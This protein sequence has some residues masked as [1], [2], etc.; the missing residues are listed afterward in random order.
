MW[1]VVEKE[2][3]RK[4]HPQDTFSRSLDPLRVAALNKYV[5]GVWAPLLAVRALFTIDENC[6]LFL[7]RA[8]QVI[9]FDSLMLQ[10]HLKQS[11]I[12]KLNVNA[13]GEERGVFKYSRLAMKWI[14]RVLSNLNF[15]TFILLLLRE[16]ECLISLSY[17][18]RSNIYFKILLLELSHSRQQVLISHF[19]LAYISMHSN[20]GYRCRL[21]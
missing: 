13:L 1:W 7:Y 2:Q 20:W 21:M 16:R 5:G 11:S 3:M 15:S 19:Y 9:A 4:K 18:W 14:A 6:A 17:W 8:Y 12:F 10:G